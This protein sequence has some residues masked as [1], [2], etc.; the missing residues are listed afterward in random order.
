MY[1]ITVF[2]QSL[3]YII[4]FKGNVKQAFFDLPRRHFSKAYNSKIRILKGSC[5][6]LD[7][8]TL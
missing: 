2:S 6:F 5:C 3:T 7:T 1:V 4:E 8:F